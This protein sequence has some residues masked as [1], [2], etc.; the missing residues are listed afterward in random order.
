MIQTNEFREIYNCEKN[1][2]QIAED[3]IKE[4]AVVFQWITGDGLSFTILL[5]YNVKGYEGNYLQRGLRKTDLFISIIPYHCYSFDIRINLDIGYMAGKLQIKDDYLVEKIH[6][7]LN[8]VRK[9]LKLKISKL[10]GDEK[11]ND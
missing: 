11:S 9:Q 7:L 6:E 5:A 2:K 1:Y 10:Y 3:L 8:G 4:K